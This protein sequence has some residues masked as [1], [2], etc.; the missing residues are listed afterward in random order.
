MGRG[1]DFYSLAKE[2][3]LGDRMAEDLNR[4][5]IGVESSAVQKY[6]AHVGQR[7]AA[8]SPGDPAVR[9][10]FTVITED[11]GEN[12]TH[13]PIA[14][15]GGYVYVSENLILAAQDESEFAGMIAHAV[16]HIAARH[17]MRMAAHAELGNLA[18]VPVVFANGDA[19]T[20]AAA[21]FQRGFESEADAVA[22]QIMAR[23][24]YDPRALIQ[25]I[26]RIQ[27]GPQPNG[28]PKVASPLPAR[29]ARLRDL[30]KVVA[31][32]HAAAL[33]RDPGDLKNIQDLLRRPAPS[34]R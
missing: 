11:R 34:L 8:Q 5:T 28:V 4:Q 13:E 16:A 14:L 2:Q 33:D 25:Y 22:L 3:S 21:A 29:E 31:D 1:V 20:A 17:G 23:A 27:P 12:P 19:V 6:V 9:Y 30:E 10:R 7:I 26:A 32:I 24:G 15:P 18:N